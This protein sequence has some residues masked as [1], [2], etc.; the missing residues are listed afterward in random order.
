VRVND[1]LPA[2]ALDGESE[3]RVG[4]GLMMRKS[5]VL[6]SPPPGWGLKTNTVRTPP[7]AMSLDEIAAVN[8]VSLMNVVGRF[9]Q[10]QRT[11]EVERKFVPVTV[12]VKSGPAAGALEGDK[13]L[14]VGNGLYSLMVNGT[15]S[16]VPPPGGGLKTVTWAVPG[17]AMSLAKMAAVST[18]L[19]T[20]LVGRSDPFQRTTDAGTK[21]E[22]LSVSVNPGS[23]AL[24]R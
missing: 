20:K 18:E 10:F 23:P 4:T 21:R 9:D 15:G 6:D 3:L 17:V 5:R 11:T 13:E 8:W 14:S 2:V 19:L 7:V 16:E 12:N 22:P 1:G 24:T